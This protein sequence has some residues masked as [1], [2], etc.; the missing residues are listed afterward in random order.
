MPN[1]YTDKEVRSRLNMPRLIDTMAQVLQDVSRKIIQQPIRTVHEIDTAGS[2]LF[3]KPV[4]TP[5]VIAVKAITQM[6]ANTANGLPSMMATLLVMDRRTGALT[7]VMEA[8]SLTNFRTAAVSA[9][10]VRQFTEPKPLVVALLGSGALA[11]SHATAIR[12]IRDVSEMR[13]WSP[14]KPNREQCAVEIHGVACSSVEQACAN[15]DVI[16]TVTLA[17]EP[18]LKGDWVKTGALVC[19]VGAPRPTWRELDSHLMLSSVVIADSRESAESES[20]DILLSGAKV[21]AEIGEIL[22]GAK[23]IEG[24]PTIVFKALGLAA[25]DAAA[26]ELV[27]SHT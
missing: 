22:L 24:Q 10:A 2:L 18:I 8:T 5:T 15:A 11:R 9:V 20:G 6:P 1:F 25:E 17:S 19:A 13:V 3:I 23:K 14:S 26:A 4:F 21:Y 12:A 7:S 27:L 16:V